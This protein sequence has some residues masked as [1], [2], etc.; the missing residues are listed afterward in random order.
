MATTSKLLRLSSFLLFPFNRVILKPFLWKLEI[1]IL[2]P[3]FQL[4]GKRKNIVSKEL[5]VKPMPLNTLVAVSGKMRCKM[6][7]L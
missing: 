4:P 2:Y 1:T 7:Q 6:I 5:G 3:G